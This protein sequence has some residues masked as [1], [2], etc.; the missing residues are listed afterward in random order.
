MDLGA[1]ILDVIAGDKSVV[2][3]GTVSAEGY[4]PIVIT[5]TSSNTA[6]TENGVVKRTQGVFRPNLPTFIDEQTVYQN[7]TVKKVIE[8]D[9]EREKIYIKKAEDGT[10]QWIIITAAVVLLGLVIAGVVAR[11]FYMQAKKDVIQAE[12]R[13]KRKTD[14]DNEVEMDSA[15]KN[16]K[17]EDKT[18]SS[19]KGDKQFTQIVSVDQYQQQY[20]PN[21]DFAI[22]NVGNDKMGGVQTLQEKM[23]LAD[24]NKSQVD[25]SSEEEEQVPNQQDNNKLKV[26]NRPSSAMNASQHSGEELLQSRDSTLPSIHNGPRDSNTPLTI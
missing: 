21:N 23:N 6:I 22:F 15:M 18:I 19:K 7:V 16:L 5:K 1:P 20:D 4:S 8:P 11:F 26:P 2:S 10:T 14:L 3:D 13:Q 25:S 24:V 17:Y 12:L 9:V